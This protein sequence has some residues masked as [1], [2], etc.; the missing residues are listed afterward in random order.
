M[1]IKSFL[2]NNGWAICLSI[3]I[4]VIIMGISYYQLG[5]YPTSDRTILASDGFGQLVN[6]YSGFN[7]VLHGKQSFFY[8]WSGSLGLN[9]VS[10][11]SYYVNSIFSFLVFF[12]DNRQ[13]PDAMYV[14]LLTKIGGMGL[15][16]WVYAHNTYRL[17]QWGKVCLSV[18]Y[19]LM[20]FT[21]A[22]SIMLMWMDALIFLPLILLGI[23]RV[24]DEQKII[25]LFATY[26]ILFITNYYT[27]FMVGVF[28]FLYFFARLLTNW[29]QYKS[30]IVP[31]LITSVLAGGAS[32]IIILPSVIDLKMNG[33]KLDSINQIFTS[34]LGPWDFVIKSMPGVYD[35][36]KYGSAPFIYIGLLPLIFFIFYF[37][38][39]KIP[40]RNKVIYGSLVLFMVASVYIEP[41]N[42][43][44]QGMHFPNMFLF[45]FSY[46]YSTVVI[47]LAG[48]GME[49]LEKKD[50]PLFVNICLSLSGLFLLAVIVSNKKRYDF[51]TQESLVLTLVF[52]SAYLLLFLS[53]KKKHKFLKFMPVVLILCI[54]LEAFFNTTQMMGG[55]DK[56]WGYTKKEAYTRSYKDINK[57]VNKTTSINDSFYRLENLD[58]VTR[59]DSFNYNYSG[60][61]MFSSVRNRRSSKYLDNLGFRSPGTNLTIMYPNNTILMDGVLGVK[62]NLSK[63]NLD[64]YGFEKIDSSGEY[65]LYE[66]KNALP[67]GMLTDEGIYQDKNNK[68]QTALL[69]QL[70]K[71]DQPLFQFTGLKEVSRENMYV[72]EEGDFT[73]YSEQMANKAQKITWEVDVP[74][75]TQAYLSLDPGQSSDMWQ[76]DVEVSVSGQKRTNSLTTVGT[77]Y[78]LGYHSKAEKVK[79]SAKFN[80][81]SIIRLIRPSV[82]VLKTD[83]FDNAMN[84][85]KKKEV[86]F[87]VKGNK[88]KAEVALEQEQV[89]FTTIP[90]DQGWQASIDGKPVE[91][92]AVQDAL[93]SVKV[94]KGKHEVVLTFY[95]KGMKLGSLLFLVCVI[96]FCLYVFWYKKMSRKIN[97]EENE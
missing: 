73:F 4:P 18:C 96:A 15:S 33:E 57:L 86:A 36:S 12:F 64:K 56:E 92:E 41:L 9:F 65:T 67:L 14:I 76:A 74:A 27:A 93:I 2:R 83:T 63:Q 87:E 44:W 8:T 10:L 55:I 20:S 22:Y 91:I 32:M 37:V 60:V 38:S 6:F 29:K 97:L 51:V 11:M 62:Y 39:K 25:L 77:Y 79:V 45:R 13:M 52:L 54:S 61:T 78:N 21:V 58:S 95:P 84:E 24:M 31:Y 40:L 26:F 42:L 43:F 71:I 59:T 46:L 69:H 49:M 35:T 75:N 3:L 19:A 72:K 70:S 23:Q 88:A 16:F 80:G 28:S 7:N 47:I 17:P 89:I 85:I 82:L 94:P 5:I 68:T 34:D 66:N 1:K 90:Y 48:F 53:K 30:S 81:Q 50:I